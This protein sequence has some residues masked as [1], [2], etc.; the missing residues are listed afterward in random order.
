MPPYFSADLLNKVFYQFTGLEEIL[1]Y[2]LAG[3]VSQQLDKEGEST[4]NIQRC[5]ASAITNPTNVANPD[6][7][8]PKESLE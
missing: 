7:V 8:P 5:P 6:V 2:R 3:D 4:K 1:R